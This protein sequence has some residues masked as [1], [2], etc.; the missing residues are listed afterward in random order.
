MASSNK[1][2]VLRR[3]SDGVVFPNSDPLRATG[4]FEEAKIEPGKG[5][6]CLDENYKPVNR[7]EYR[8]QIEQRRKE[9]IDKAKEEFDFE[10]EDAKVA[11]TEA[12]V[13]SER[14]RSSAGVDTSGDNG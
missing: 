11:S 6:D 2:T 10:V 4:R 5:I 12:A 13:R 1:V 8:K 7:V 3:I 14:Q 9:R